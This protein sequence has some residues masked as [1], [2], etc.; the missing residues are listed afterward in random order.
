MTNTITILAIVLVGFSVPS[1]FA[2]TEGNVQHWMNPVILS[3]IGI[4]LFAVSRKSE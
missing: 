4:G 2:C 3:G 1:A